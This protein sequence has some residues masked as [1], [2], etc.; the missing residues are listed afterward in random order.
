MGIEGNFLLR[1]GDA[2]LKEN[3]LQIATFAGNEVVNFDFKT[4]TWYHIACVY[5]FSLNDYY[6][7]TTIYINGEKVFEIYDHGTPIL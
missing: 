5:T 2:G 1:F 6:A 7:S 4:K 3:T